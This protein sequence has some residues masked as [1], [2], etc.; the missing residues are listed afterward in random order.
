MRTRAVIGQRISEL[1]Q[2]RMMTRP[3]LAQRS[4]ISR[5]YLWHVKHGHHAPSL[6]TL[7][8]VACS[9]DVSLNRLFS[10]SEILLE[11]AVVRELL[12][13]LPK[14]NLQ[15]RELILKTLQAAPRAT[16]RNL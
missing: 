4:R 2:L 6:S 7:E 1:R 11:D 10:Q 16:N 12:G 5:S 14:L 3:Q 8:K 15:N 9:L 13:L